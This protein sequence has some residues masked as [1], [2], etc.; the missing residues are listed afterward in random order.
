MQ[1]VDEPLQKHTL[2][3]YAG[4]YD[5]IKALYPQN[6]PATMIREIVR[7]HLNKTDQRIGQVKTEDLVRIAEGVSV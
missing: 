4:D 6:Y 2:H 1:K 7:A 3:L 5:R